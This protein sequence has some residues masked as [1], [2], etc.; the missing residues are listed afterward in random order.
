MLKSGIYCISSITQPGKKYIG[1]AKCLQARRHRHFRELRRKCH[2]N[3]KLSNHV[4]K[5]GIE[6]LNF[7]IVLLC[8][9]AQLLFW[10]QIFLDGIK[11]YF[12]LCMV[13]GSQAGTSHSNQTKNKISK[14]KRERPRPQP[15]KVLRRYTI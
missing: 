8:P 1:S 11:P 12:N 9:E 13:A 3:S 10:E 4:I 2:H 6:D 7:E 14:S 5:Y 15:E